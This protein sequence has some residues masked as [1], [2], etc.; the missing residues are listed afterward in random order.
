MFV[1]KS[2]AF[3]GDK[4]QKPLPFGSVDVDCNKASTRNK[5]TR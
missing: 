5:A 2:D 1:C 4:L 3:S